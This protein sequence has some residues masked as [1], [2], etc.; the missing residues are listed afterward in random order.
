[1]KAGAAQPPAPPPPPP[2]AST[3][4]HVPLSCVAGV[5]ADAVQLQNEAPGGAANPAVVAPSAYPLL[6]A[7]WVWKRGCEKGAPHLLRALQTA[8]PATTGDLADVDI[9]VLI[10]IIG[11]GEFEATPAALIERA[12]AKASTRV[13]RLRAKG[14]NTTVEA[15]MAKDAAE[16]AA[17]AERGEG[18]SGSSDSDGSK[19]PAR[20]RKGG[21]AAASA[22]AT[23]LPPSLRVSTR[24]KAVEVEDNV[25]SLVRMRRLL[26]AQEHA[27]M[28]LDN[29][30]RQGVAARE[31]TRA[32][33]ASLNT[34]LRVFETE[35][36]RSALLAAASLFSRGWGGGGGAGGGADPAAPSN[37]LYDQLRV[38]LDR[39]CDLN[40]AIAASAPM[41]SGASSWGGGGG[42]GGGGG[43]SG[44]GGGSSGGGG[45]GHAKSA[46]ISFGGKTPRS[47]PLSQKFLGSP[48]PTSSHKKGS[49]GSVSHKKGAS[50]MAAMA[51]AAAAAAASEWD[52]VASSPPLGL[53]PPPKVHKRRESKVHD[54]SYLTRVFNTNSRPPPTVRL[55][56]P[57]PPGPPK[58]KVSH[59]K[60]MG[61]AAMAAR[62]AAAAAAA[63]AAGGE[64]A[65][66]G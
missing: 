42:G 25:R 55:P 11:V 65:T 62:A 17:A 29:V 2:A 52:A 28:L 33:V 18:S 53:P 24:G 47:S 16:A 22:E 46:G 45:G 61:K 66:M 7:Y 57:P 44:G 58:E 26:A 10:S 14:I 23:T 63:A 1:M 13:A 15:L 3:C 32:S 6:H 5:L 27:R 51:A 34:A 31:R 43:S 49:S 20:S 64:D 4:F 50:K 59:K 8:G 56:P 36:N 41:Y 40:A 35:G 9:G 38:A 21:G 30:R 12:R 37:A 54:T 60:G 19:P 48:K 39:S